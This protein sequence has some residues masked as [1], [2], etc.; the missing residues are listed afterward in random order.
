MNKYL[1]I[2]YIVWNI[3]VYAVYGIDK[4]RAKKDIWRI[5]EKTLMLMALCMGGVGAYV[6]MQ[7]FRHKTKHKLFKFGVPVCIVL[8]L[9]L[10]YFLT[11]FNSLEWWFFR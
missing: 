2:I 10:I 11:G 8:N 7:S 6:G 4:Y 5:P 1:L 3:I 9:L